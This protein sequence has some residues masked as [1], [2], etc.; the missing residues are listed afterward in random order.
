[1]VKDFEAVYWV[2]FQQFLVVSYWYLY[3]NKIDF[4]V[5]SNDSM[6]ERRFSSTDFICFLSLLT[7]FFSFISSSGFYCFS[8][9]ERELSLAIKIK[10][11]LAVLGVLNDLLWTFLELVFKA[12]MFLKKF[13][14]YFLLF[15]MRKPFYIK[16]KGKNIYLSYSIPALKISCF[17]LRRIRNHSLLLLLIFYFLELVIGIVDS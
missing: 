7:S 9:G 3:T 11:F 14:I 17:F 13:C 12:S 8:W 5:V 6:S 16:I 2:E 1:M 4:N 15:E 10:K